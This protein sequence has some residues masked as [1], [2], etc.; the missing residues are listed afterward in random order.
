MVKVYLREDEQRNSGRLQQVMRKFKKMCDRAG[1][2]R[3]IR[4][5]EFYEKP[6]E[7][8]KRKDLRNKINFQRKMKELE[9]SRSEQIA[10]SG[11]E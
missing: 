8:R 1:I 5:H 4:R 10:Q 7:I 9:G 2:S 11:G 6:C 3:D